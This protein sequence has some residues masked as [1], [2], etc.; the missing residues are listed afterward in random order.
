MGAFGIILFIV[1]IILL[2]KFP[3][4]TLFISVGLILLCIILWWAL[5]TI[6]DNR[7]KNIM[8]GINKNVNITVS[9]SLSDC[10]PGFP[11][12]VT[13][14]N[15]SN[16]TITKVSWEVNIYIPGFSKD[17][18]GYDNRYDSDKI[19]RPG[20]IWLSCYKLPSKI[21][22]KNHDLSSLQYEISHKDVQFRD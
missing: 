18:S 9:Y 12:L 19:L 10:N 5:I 21:D 8:E 2:F 6:P 1:M 13:I 20:E 11:L 7:Q 4:Q 22:A 17:I 15:N 14:K 16:K 3:K